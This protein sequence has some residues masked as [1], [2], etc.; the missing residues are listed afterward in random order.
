MM[1]RLDQ[2]HA[3]WEADGSIAPL[4][5]TWQD[6]EYTVQSVG[7]SWRDADGYHVLCMPA[8]ND[9]FELLL[10]PELAWYLRPPAGRRLG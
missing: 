3:R 1:D 7:R 6:R 10:T 8:G 2:I 4:G 9:V 5:F